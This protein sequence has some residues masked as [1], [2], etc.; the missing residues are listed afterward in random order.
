MQILKRI[1]PLAF[2]F[3]LMLLNSLLNFLIVPARGASGIMWQ[4]Y[5]QEEEI[6]TIFVG[7]S[8]C[9]ATFDPYIFNK[10]IGVK[11]FNMGTPLQAIEQTISAVET[12]I[13]DYKL[14]TIVIGMGFFS[15]QQN[16]YDKAEMTFER[17]KAEKKSGIAGVL[18]GFRYILSEDIRGTEKSINYMFPWLYNQGEISWEAIYRNVVAKI[19]AYNTS[20]ENGLS[21]KGYSYY[22]GI[23]DYGTAREIN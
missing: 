6:D 2:V 21:K 16:S 5:Y 14:E 19:N 15:L 7:A 13:E 22:D 17:A 18:E 11:S 1:K 9:A 20:E 3:V 12:A 10:E 8:F 4:E 23:L